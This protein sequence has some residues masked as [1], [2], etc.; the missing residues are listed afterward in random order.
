MEFHRRI[1]FLR[2]VRARV[3]RPS[4]PYSFAAVAALI[5][6]CSLT[7]IVVIAFVSGYLGAL[8]GLAVRRTLQHVFNVPCLVLTLDT[9][10]LDAST[11]ACSPFV[12]APFSELE[13]GFLTAAARQKILKPWLQ[14]SASD[15]TN[16]SSVNIYMNHVRMWQ[17]INKTS[18]V[19]LILEED[20][21]VPPN[22]A[23]VVEQV[24]AALRQDNVTNFVVKLIDSTNLYT[25]QWTRVYSV[26]GY[27]VLT[28]S[29]RPSVNS[30][31]SAAYL[32]D[33]AAANTLLQS[34]F[35]ASTHVDVYTHN[36]GCIN[37][38]IRLFKLSPHLMHSNNRPTAHLP[39]TF[40]RVYLL[41]KEIIVNLV[42]STC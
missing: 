20:V 24:L 35:P 37:K 16:N 25:S 6:C 22:A 2:R 19:A 32:I 10:R 40:H 14:E 4:H 29:C 11:A 17:Q 30:A 28:C 36:M 34:A 1:R 8:N 42:Y 12:P 33:S 27:D 15:L 38:K 41:Y 31:S 5:A 13:L 3:P 18:N 7:C 23:D 21:M 26:A 39:L 9:S